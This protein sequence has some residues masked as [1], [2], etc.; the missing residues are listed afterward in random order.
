MSPSHESPAWPLVLLFLDYDG[1]L[2]TPALPDFIDFEF[3]PRFE[4]LLREYPQVGVVVT[5]THRDGAS[6]R[7]LQM[8][9]SRDIQ[10]RVI[11]ATPDLIDGRKDGGRYQEIL[12]Y[13]QAT[14]W[15]AK[16][17]IALDDDAWLYPQGCPQLLLTS[18]YEGFDDLIEEELR[19]R[20]DA[21]L[22]RT[23]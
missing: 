1:V 17:W 7:Q 8:L 18:K 12:A 14:G 6:L 13:L 9:Y 10:P 22:K 4:R 2:Q 20:L 21:L 11:G 3:L 23:S 19:A 16:P 15:A 5:S